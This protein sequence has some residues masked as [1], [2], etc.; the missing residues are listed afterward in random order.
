MNETC[1]FCESKELTTAESVAEF[2]DRR[3]K[4]LLT[5]RLVHTE[6]RNCE[7]EFTTHAQGVEN[8]ARIE[9]ARRAAGGAPGPEEIVM[10]RKDVMDLTQAEAGDLFGGGPVAFSKYE[11]GTIVPAQSMARLLSLAV[12]GVITR[13]DL[14]QAASGTLVTRAAVAISAVAESAETGRHA[15][16]ARPQASSSMGFLQV[17]G[18][19]AVAKIQ[20]LPSGLI[21][22]FDAG[23]QTSPAVAPI[24]TFYATHNSTTPWLQ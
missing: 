18:Q 2:N 9:A 15:P 20:Y 1:P 7:R 6:C 14:E 22:P 19:P 4:Q 11:N 12:A 23:S 24:T 8:T 16:V 10:M 21:S 3:K 5:V 17:I 13:T